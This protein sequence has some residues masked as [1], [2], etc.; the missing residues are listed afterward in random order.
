MILRRLRRGKPMPMGTVNRSLFRHHHTG[1]WREGS[2][3]LRHPARRERLPQHCRDGFQ[4]RSFKPVRASQMDGKREG[5][6]AIRRGGGESFPSRFNR[7]REAKLKKRA[8][9]GKTC[10]DKPSLKLLLAPKS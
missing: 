1:S 6:C 10:E 3:R 4:A 2:F 8:A 5:K 9:R 7:L